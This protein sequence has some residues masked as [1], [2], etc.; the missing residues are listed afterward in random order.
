MN[1]VF[2]ATGSGVSITNAI[3]KR[4]EEAGV[5]I[6]LE[7]KATELITEDGKVTGVKAEGSDGTAYEIYADAVVLA[8]GGYGANS[9]LLTDALA[10]TPTTA[11]HAAPATAT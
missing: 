6:L 7:T 4:C 3:E 9:D 1:R 5:E 8:T 10:A 11:Q 2:L